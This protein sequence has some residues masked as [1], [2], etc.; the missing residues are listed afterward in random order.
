MAGSN[1]NLVGYFVYC[2]AKN[3]Y[4]PNP[5]EVLRKGIERT[6]G[7]GTTAFKIGEMMDKQVQ[8][9]GWALCWKNLDHTYKSRWL[10]LRI[11]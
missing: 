4:Y 1:N 3:Y 10:I 5:L 8:K 6:V 2:V 11:S 7:R 9:T